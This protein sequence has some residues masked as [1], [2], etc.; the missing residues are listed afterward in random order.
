MRKRQFTAEF[1]TKVVLE[2]LREEKQ[3]GELASEHDIS[4]NQLRNWKKEFLENATR[5]FDE[6]RREKGLRTREKELEDEHNIL[7]AKVGQLTIENDWLKKNPLK[8]LDLTTRKNLISPNSKLSIKQQCDLLEINRSSVY[9]TPAIANMER[10]ELIKSRLDY[11]HT[12]MCY[13][14]VRRLKAKLAEDGIHVGRKLIKRQMEEM[15]IYCIYP[16]PNLSKRNLTHKI[17]PYLLRNISITLPNQVWAVDIT[18][19]KMGRSHMYLTAIIDWYSRYIVG[20]A[21]SD[22]LDT[23]PVLEAVSNAITKYGK[24]GIINV[25]VKQPAPCLNLRYRLTISKSK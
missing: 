2:L 17:H 5:V 4:P 8:C 11:W 1:K 3:L 6:N 18:Y 12:K 19:I 24:P 15:G 14:G 21:L 7:M 10:D 9:Y 25:S 22:T 23:A 13:L 20:W 16:K